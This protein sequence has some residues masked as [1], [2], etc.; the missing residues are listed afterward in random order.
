MLTPADA[1]LLIAQHVQV[2]AGRAEPLARC[3]GRVL[4]E[5][6]FAERDQPPFDRVMMDGIAVDSAVLRA[7]SRSLPVEGL[8]AAGIP[9]LTLASKNACIEVT[10]G[11]VLPQGCDAVIPV[12]RIELVA[13][14]ARIPPELAIAEWQHVHRRGSDRR[15]GDMLL[16]A[17]VRLGPAEVAI[18][19]GAGKSQALISVPPVPMLVSTGDELVEPGMPILDHQIRRS[20]VYGM[21]AA[22]QRH[23]FSEVSLD[24]VRDDAAVLRQQLAAHLQQHPVLLLS[25]GVS[26]G[27]LDFVPSVLE[28]LGVRRVFHRIAQRP[29]KPLWFGVGDAGQLVFALPGNP[30][31]TLVCLVRYVIP[32]LWHALGLRQSV[33]ESAALA[34]P[35]VVRDD[36]TT[37]V[38]ARLE[39]DDTGRLWAV[40]QS[41]NNSGDFT[42]LAGTDGFIELP[43]GP[44]SY[45]KGFAARFY[46]W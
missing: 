41:G 23:G 35:V 28:E 4:R 26:M 16:A 25:G 34:E 36:T 45:A 44:Q 38:P 9:A 11:A 32:A 1:E 24:H 12:E 10:T 29:G 5:D 22:L 14:E 42:A 3:V 8:Q 33:A 7:G 21:L 37:F 2:L 40:P 19:A 15:Q 27:K 43:P 46:R 31:S 20:N 30:V 18:I 6:I 17:G 13:S 39:S